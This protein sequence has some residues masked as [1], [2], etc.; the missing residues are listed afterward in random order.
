MAFWMFTFVGNFAIYNPFSLSYS[1]L[2]GLASGLYHTVA[3]S[4]ATIVLSKSASDHLVLQRQRFGLSRQL[5]SATCR[6]SCDCHTTRHESRT[7]EKSEGAN[8]PDAAGRVL[9]AQEH[10]CTVSR[11][12][13]LKASIYKRVSI[14]EKKKLPQKQAPYAKPSF[15]STACYCRE[16]A[17][18]FMFDWM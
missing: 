15:P 10:D 9:V 12:R 14:V 1:R 7:E 13:H 18:R 2:A 11:Y 4:L 5:S 8:P 6:L 16:T 17:S 3:R